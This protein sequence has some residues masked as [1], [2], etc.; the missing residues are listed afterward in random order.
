[1]EDDAAYRR[2]KH[3]VAAL[4]GFYTHLS[5][6]VLVMSLLLVINLSTYGHWWVQWVLL[7][8]GIGILAHAFSVFGP[9]SWL[10]PEWE[11]RKI[12]EYMSKK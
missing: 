11:E 2:A 8:W 10:G 1:M 9:A 12:K 6:F 5:V 3:R 4:K 7:G